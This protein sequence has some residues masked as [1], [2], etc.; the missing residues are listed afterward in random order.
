[1]NELGD[2]MR[3]INQRVALTIPLHQF[4]RFSEVLQLLRERWTTD[5]EGYGGG[6]SLVV[7]EPHNFTESSLLLIVPT[8]NL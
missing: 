4:I 3:G 1:M 8:S 6:F 7:D 2:S 5:C